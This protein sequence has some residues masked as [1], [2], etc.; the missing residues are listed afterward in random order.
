[1]ISS[2]AGYFVTHRLKSFHLCYNVVPKLGYKNSLCQFHNPIQYDETGMNK[3]H[4][5]SIIIVNHNLTTSQ[6]NLTTSKTTSSPANRTSPAA[7]PTAPLAASIKKKKKKC[8][9]DFNQC[10]ILH[11]DSP[12]N[13]YQS[14]RLDYVAGS[15]NLMHSFNVILLIVTI[16]HNS[17][18]CFIVTILDVLYFYNN[19]DILTDYMTSCCRLSTSVAT[20]MCSSHRALQR[21]RARSNNETTWGGGLFIYSLLVVLQQEERA[22]VGAANNY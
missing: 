6:C 13:P 10:R 11:Y 3:S 20:G 19:D 17:V 2:Y 7:T 8:N 22:P 12:T 15:R 16:K 14:S 4:E 9:L 21:F 5:M 1:M 18:L